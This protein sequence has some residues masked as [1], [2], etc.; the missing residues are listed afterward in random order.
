[1]VLTAPQRA[2]VL[3]KEII[4]S[5]DQQVPELYQQEDL[6][7]GF[8]IATDRHGVKRSFPLLTI[9]IAITLS[10]NMIQP[11]PLNISL[12]CARMKE[13]LKRLKNSNY[14]IDRRK[15]LP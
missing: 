10:E 12:N 7:A 4:R 8:V 15:Q 5:F 14:L 9:S 11:S 3:A 13:H 6:E 1:M 2:E